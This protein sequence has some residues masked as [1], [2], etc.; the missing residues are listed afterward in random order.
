MDL[1]KKDLDM[2][3]LATLRATRT[4]TSTPSTSARASIKYQYGGI[5]IC[6]AAFMFVHAIG[7]H[8]LK[9]L[10]SHYD[11]NGLSERV[12]GNVRKRPHN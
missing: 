1:D 11:E 6:K 7:A 2:A 8:R 5:Q 9:N 10:I 3:V 4:L 12:H